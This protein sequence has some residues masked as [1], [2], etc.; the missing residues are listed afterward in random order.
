MH[1]CNYTDRLQIKNGLITRIVHAEYKGKK[2]QNEMDC[3][4]HNENNKWLC[5]NVVYNCYNQYGVIFAEEKYYTDV[6]GLEKYSS[7]NPIPFYC[8][9]IPSQSDIE[10][11]KD[12]YPTLHSSAFISNEHIINSIYFFKK[13]PDLYNYLSDKGL[14]QIAHTEKTYRLS[15]NKI[16]ELKNFLSENTIPNTTITRALQ[17]IKYTKL[18]PGYK[19]C[20]IEDFLSKIDD[21]DERIKTLDKLHC[22]KNLSEDKK[23][24]YISYIKENNI[25]L[26]D[27]S[28]LRK[29][30][31]FEK[32]P[33]LPIHYS[34]VADD[35]LKT[36]QQVIEYYDSGIKYILKKY[37]PKS[38][39]EL[40]N[41]IEIYKK[42]H[43]RKDLEALLSVGLTNIAL[44][45][46][47]YDFDDERKKTIKTF[48]RKNLEA[49][50]KTDPYYYTVEKIVEMGIYES[51]IMDK[52]ISLA[53]KDYYHK[54]RQ[55]YSYILNNNI[56]YAD[57]TH[58]MDLLS[59]LGHDKENEYWKYPS[60]FYERL[61]YVE[62]ED[63]KRTEAMDRETDE[64]YMKAVETFIKENPQMK[65]DGYE[66]FIPE[67]IADIRKQAEVLSQCLIRMNYPK[68]VIEEDSLLIFLR[69]DGK[70]VATCEIS[71]NS[72]LIKQFYQDERDRATCHATKEQKDVMNKWLEKAV[73][74]EKEFS[75]LNVA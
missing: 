75:M 67:N 44:C 5:R 40:K 45:S 12:R 51:D 70:P 23:N 6:M 9:N 49:C 66:V 61:S 13:N 48:I 58:Y 73:I 22:F 11:V 17:I 2:Y 68:K 38:E 1:K 74:T 36:T 47:F 30:K 16:K 34:F 28:I 46:S 60:D 32:Y 29:T 7:C 18:L 52:I 72:K 54:D 62:N 19:V 69:I 31:L 3:V 27:K 71:K 24:D 55:F 65:I 25:R 39:N 4:K 37:T 15:E 20:D 42:P 63:R 8:P 10:L 53:E 64:K 14:M 35:C 21:M 43:A 26:A 50:Q 59:V 41:I 56:E 33:S 57:Y